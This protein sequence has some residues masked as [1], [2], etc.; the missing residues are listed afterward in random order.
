MKYC[1][2]DEKIASGVSGGFVKYVQLAQ[3]NGGTYK[4]SF[5][6][7]MSHSVGD[8]GYAIVSLFDKPENKRIQNIL[9]KGNL[10]IMH[11][12]VIGMP[13]ERIIRGF[14]S[15]KV[16]VPNQIDLIRFFGG[17]KPGVRNFLKVKSHTAPV[18]RRSG[19]RQRG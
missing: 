12:A 15:G 5:S 19:Q 16:A 10:L 7:R 2:G 4:L 13:A 14:L 8:K 18:E 3:T 1:N 9:P 6:Y 11:V 17:G